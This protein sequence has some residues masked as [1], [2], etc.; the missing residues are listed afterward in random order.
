MPIY[1]HHGVGYLWLMDPIGKTLDT[2]RLESNKWVISASFYEDDKVRAEPF[3]EIEFDLGHLWLGFQKLTSD[4]K[5][6]I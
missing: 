2:Y 6:T 3:Q 5:G 4:S 1:A